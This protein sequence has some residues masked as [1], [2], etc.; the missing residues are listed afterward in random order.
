MISG[1]KQRCLSGVL[2]G[3]WP[4]ERFSRSLK[5]V[6]DGR[7]HYEIMKY[8]RIIFLLERQPGGDVRKVSGGTI[9]VLDRRI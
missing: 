4:L 3:Y 6:I 7:A 5:D 8:I 9:S 1:G 2:A